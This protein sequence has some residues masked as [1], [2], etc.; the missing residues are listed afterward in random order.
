MLALRNRLS[1][2]S[3]EDK[4]KAAERA[5]AARRELGR[6]FIG[7]VSA[8]ERK[9]MASAMELFLDGRM[10]VLSTV[11]YL[12]TCLLDDQTELHLATD[13]KGSMFLSLLRISMVNRR[14]RGHYPTA[15]DFM[16]A[17]DRVDQ[18]FF[19]K[20]KRELITVSDQ[21]PPLSVIKM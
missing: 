7:I 11:D 1:V 21:A 5:E 13:W 17:Y 3:S 10:Y 20:D 12:Y 18:S 6:I 2:S 8:L 4:K 16:A 19:R 14:V 9:K 15:E